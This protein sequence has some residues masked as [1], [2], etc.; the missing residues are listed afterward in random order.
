M[1]HTRWVSWGPP[2][3]NTYPMRCA[4]VHLSTFGNVVTLSYNPVES[5]LFELSVDKA[6]PTRSS[7]TYLSW[8]TYRQSNSSQQVRN[9][10]AMSMYAYNFRNRVEQ[11]PCPTSKPV[12]KGSGSMGQLNVQPLLRNVT[13]WYVTIPGQE[14]LEDRQ[15]FQRWRWDWWPHTWP[16][17]NKKSRRPNQPKKFCYNR[18]SLYR[19]A[20]NSINSLAMDASTWI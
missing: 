1:G 9:P 3:S 12:K 13:F 8:V 5:T 4:R 6:T 10:G 14:Y 11:P 15:G 20:T 7:G 17:K 2:F 19:K 18:P 16:K